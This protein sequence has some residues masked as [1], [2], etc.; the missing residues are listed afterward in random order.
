MTIDAWTPAD[1]LLIAWAKLTRLPLAGVTE[2][3]VPFTVRVKLAEEEIDVENG[4]ATAGKVALLT[5]LVAEPR[6]TTSTVKV[7]A[8]APAPAPRTTTRTC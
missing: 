5:V 8:S 1:E 3:E 2:N 6:L 7:P 4:S